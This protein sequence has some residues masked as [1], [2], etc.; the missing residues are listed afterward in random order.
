[1][2]SQGM[3]IQDPLF[4]R[5]FN[6]SA[7]LETSFNSLP[8][9]SSPIPLSSFLFP[10]PQSLANSEELILVLPTLGEGQRVR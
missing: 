8:L 9:F 7:E 5:D 10:C 6:S 3:D 1:M 2:G 4:V